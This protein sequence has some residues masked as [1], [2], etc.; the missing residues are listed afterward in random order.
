[1]ADAR[2]LAEDFGRILMLTLE[3]FQRRL[4]ADLARRGVRGIGRRHRA[5]FL[6]LGRHGASRAVDLAA[7]AGIRPQ[8]MMK[9]IDELE[10]LGLVERRPDPDDSRAKRVA[11]TRRGSRLIEELGRSTRTV[12]DEYAR[13]A[14]AGEIVAA[15]ATLD[16][17][18]AAA[19]QEES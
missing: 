11:F 4:D 2:E 19:G 12:W 15:F 8:S 13:L 14:G 6:H 17:L 18:L 1:M 7:A 9:V 16:R 10:A 3:D 5:V